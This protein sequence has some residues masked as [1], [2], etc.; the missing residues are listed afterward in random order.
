MKY[1]TCLALV[2][3]FFYLPC[4]QAEE[5]REVVYFYENYC[6]TCRE[7]E[8]FADTFFALTG[9]QL[10]DFQF[11]GYNVVQQAARAV[12]EGALD[13]LGIET[14]S[15]PLIIVDD[16]VYQGSRLY[17]DLPVDA[18]NW[19]D[20]IDSTII[21]LFV[22][23][24]ESCAR[25]VEV[26]EALPDSVAVTRGKYTFSSAVSVNAIDISANP[27]VADALFEAYGVP[28]EQ[29]VVPITFFGDRY[30]SGADAIERSLLRSIR[31]GCAVGGIALEDF[32]ENKSLRMIN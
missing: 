15:L 26:L 24:C 30:L 4:A 13:R 17:Y 27:E 5:K 29:R 31:L 2:L 23:A 1:L 18:L 10:T 19:S 14:A 32:A 3:I 20:T 22:P 7:E 8:A 16:T 28:D 9:R 11:K 12:Y 21:Y 6:E 25:A